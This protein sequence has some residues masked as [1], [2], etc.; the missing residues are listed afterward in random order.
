MILSSASRKSLIP[1][2]F[3]LIVATL[4]VEFLVRFGFVP[5]FILPAPSQVAQS[6]WQD[7]G[8][9]LVGAGETFLSAL[10]GLLLS[11]VSGTLF[12]A[13]LALSDW[14]RRAFLP[15]AVFFQTVP[16]IAIAPVLVIWFGFGRPTVVSAACIVSVFP[17]VVNTLL[18]LESVE[19]TWLDLFYL[20][21][22]TSLQVLFKLRLPAAL[23]QIFSGLRIASGLAIVG[24][25]VG[26][27][28]G[29]GGLGS[30]IDAART[31]QRLDQVFAAVMVLSLLGL[32]LVSLVNLLSKVVLARHFFKR[33]H[34]V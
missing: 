34:E 31:Q 27:F 32:L 25:T 13:V 19:A 15:F 23:P 10:I 11:F 29:G 2:F 8:E 1:P 20:Y 18:G 28:V 17:I 24:A 16:I 9:I 4:T 30:F 14:A 7:R 5:S 21:R 12:A 3:V 6:L 33:P 26:E 22:A